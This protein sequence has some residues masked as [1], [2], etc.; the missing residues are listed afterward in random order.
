MELIFMVAGFVSTTRSPRSHTILLLVSIVERFAATKG[1][2]A[3][4]PQVLGAHQDLGA[5]DRLHLRTVDIHLTRPTAL[6]LLR[7]VGVQMRI[8][9]GAD[10]RH[11]EGGEASAGRCRLHV[12][13]TVMLTSLEEL[14]GTMTG[15]GGGVMTTMSPGGG[16]MTMLRGHATW[17]HPAHPLVLDETTDLALAPPRW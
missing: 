4:H 3:S 5:V 13:E 10:A 8:L 11:R 14:L 16:A 6:R 1:E 7:E 9:I 2:A 15:P 12:G 17:T